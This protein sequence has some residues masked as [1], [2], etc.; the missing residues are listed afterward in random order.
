MVL[1]IING[2]SP[3]A[4]LMGVVVS[5]FTLP[6]A[7][8]RQMELMDCQAALTSRPHIL[9]T[10]LRTFQE[11]AIKQNLEIV[12]MAPNPASLRFR[13]QRGYVAKTADLKEC[14][15]ATSGPIQ[16]LVHCPEAAFKDHAEWLAT[17]AHLST[18]GYEVLGPD[19]GYLVRRVSDGK[20]F[21]SDYDL[22]SVRDRHTGQGSFSEAL[23]QEIN[24]R[25]G[26]R[27]VRHG[28][29]ADYEL[30]ANVNIK[31]PLLIITPDS[32]PV[33]IETRAELEREFK[34]RNLPLW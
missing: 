20:Y 33:T 13:S 34:A 19:R 16:G 4:L 14:K 31:L 22:F 21:F 9:P 27:L 6:A 32:G 3:L 8:A 18:L 11:I 23:R 2:L 24:E 10:D 29:L 30:R 28:P 17:K 7:V 15:T 26:R 5:A 1:K 25:L 12:V